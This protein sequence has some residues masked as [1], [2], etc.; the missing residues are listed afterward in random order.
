MAHDAP[1]TDPQPA[2]RPSWPVVDDELIEQIA[3]EADVD[4][5]SVVRRL[6]GLPV[7]G[8]PGRRVDEILLRLRLLVVIEGR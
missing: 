4:R 3:R 6:A 8:K 2:P 7:K 1:S 5:R